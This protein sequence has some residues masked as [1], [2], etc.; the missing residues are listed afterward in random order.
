MTYFALNPSVTYN[1][2]PI[3]VASKVEVEADISDK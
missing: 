3:G 2:L 1:Y